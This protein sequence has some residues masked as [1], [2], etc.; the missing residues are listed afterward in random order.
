MLRIDFEL[1][2]GEVDGAGAISGYAMAYMTL[3]GSLGRVSSK[4]RSPLQTMMVF[5]SIVDLLDGLRRLWQSPSQQE[6]CFVG[7]DSSFQARFVLEG[8]STLKVTCGKIE[9]CH[10]SF[11]LIVHSVLVDV[12]RFLS[13]VPRPPE[14]VVGDLDLSISQFRSMLESCDTL[15]KPENLK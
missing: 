14:P 9:I 12:E 11:S 13:Q 8:R 1:V 10:D 4:E 7:T 2:A 6:Y 5:L 15:H 3:E